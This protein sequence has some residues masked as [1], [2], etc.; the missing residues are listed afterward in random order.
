[1][2]NTGLSIL[3][4]VA[5]VFTVPYLFTRFSSN[6]AIGKTAPSFDQLLPEAADTSKTLYFYFM[7]NNCPMCSSMS[8]L[9]KELQTLNP[10]II[11]INVNEMPDLV[12]DFYVYGTPTLHAVKNNIIVKS[13]L[14]GLSEKKLNQFI[15]NQ[16]AN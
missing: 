3:L 15:D 10:N 7:S 4:I 1:M 16:V 5:V 2:D 6:R 12:R 9:I 13:K 11:Y 8:P 14:G